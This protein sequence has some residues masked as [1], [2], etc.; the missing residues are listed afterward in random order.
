MQEA[1]SPFPWCAEDR[2]D[3]IGPVEAEGD[4]IGFSIGKF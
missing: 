4:F 3:S 1:P 2:A